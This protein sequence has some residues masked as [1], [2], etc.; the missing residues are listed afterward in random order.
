MIPLIR[1]N[2][3]RTERMADAQLVIDIFEVGIEDAAS[4][5]GLRRT[6]LRQFAKTDAG[7]EKKIPLEIVSRLHSAFYS[8]I[9]QNDLNNFRTKSLLVQ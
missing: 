6:I 3:S 1:S 5:S 7:Y 4:M 9:T 8:R 2:T